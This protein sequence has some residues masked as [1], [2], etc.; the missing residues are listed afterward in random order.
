MK[1]NNRIRSLII[2]ILAAITL[3]S[4]CSS[5]S[6]GEMP[7]DKPKYELQIEV[8]LE[9]NILLNTYDVEVNIDGEKIG[10]VKQGETFSG[11]VSLEEGK[12]EFKVN[13]S[14][15]PSVSGSTTIDITEDAFFSCSIKSRTGGIDIND[16]I[17]ETLTAHAERV[18]RE[19]AE[20]AEAEA[21]EKAEQE[22]QEAEMQAELDAMAEEQQ[23]V[24]A[25]KSALAGFEG[26]RL[27]DV[28]EEISSL[29]IPVKYI[30]TNSNQDMTSVIGDVTSSYFIEKAELDWLGDSATIRITPESVIEDQKKR[31]ELTAVLDPFDA[32]LAAEQ[33][34][35]YIYGSFELH[36]FKGKLAEEPEEDG[37]AWFLK[38]YCTVQNG[39]EMTCEATVGGTTADPVVLY[40][41]VY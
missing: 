32:W 39:Y 5:G 17:E 33:Y 23:K 25:L 28:Y 26:K 4:G 41:N 16:Q 27:S 7:V 35:E 12:H 3:L 34:G 21:A 13:K 30:A 36:Y 24:D 8:Y 11:T 10:T 1:K 14:G 2:M 22:R 6:G 37:T 15:D 19:E 31:A 9:T 29:G 40:F 20:R 18:E 38:A